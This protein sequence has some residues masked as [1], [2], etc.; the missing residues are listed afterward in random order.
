MEPVIPDGVIF[1]V[2]GVLVDVRGSFLAAIARTL[3][4]VFTR[5]YGLA[6][7]APLVDDALIATFKRAGGY[8]NDWDLAYG[9]ALWYRAALARTQRRT[10][11]LRAAAGDPSAAAGRSLRVHEAA[12][13]GVSHPSFED[14]R[15]LMLELYWGSEEAARRFGVRPRLAN[16]APLSAAERVLL[17]PQTP[18]ALRALGVERFGVITGRVRAEWEAIRARLPLPADTPVATDEDGRKPD[19]ELLA[20]LVARMRVRRPCY[21][22]DVA[23]DWALVLAYNASPHGRARP[24]RGVLVCAA[25]EEDAFRGMGATLFARDVNELPRVLARL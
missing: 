12:V 22:G 21:V 15:G 17:R 9:L 2:D 11:E 13:A 16:E 10:S 14:V 5:E 20:R 6:D 8:N 24:A 25:A 4:W 1:D 23:D 19:P 7:D 18:E 3:Q